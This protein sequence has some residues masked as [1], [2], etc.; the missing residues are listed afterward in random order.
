MQYLRSVCNKLYTDGSRVIK[1]TKQTFDHS[2]MMFKWRIHKLG[3]FIHKKRKY[4]AESSRDVGSHQPPS[5]M[6]WH[7]LRKFAWDE[8]LV[9]RGDG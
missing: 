6:W 5:S 4:M 1:I 7:F 2:P 8:G 9:G 3:E